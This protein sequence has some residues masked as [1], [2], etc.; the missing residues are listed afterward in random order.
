MIKWIEQK[1]CPLC[2]CEDSKYTRQG[3]YPVIASPEILGGCPLAVLTYRWTCLDCGLEYQSPRMSDESLYEFYAS[4]LYRSYINDKQDA[5]DTYERVRQQRVVEHLQHGSV[6]D[7]GC[8][9]GYLLEMAKKRDPHR[10]VMGVEPYLDYVNPNVPT[11]RRIEDVS[12]RWDNVIC[13]HVI[14]HIGPLVAFCDRLI[15][16]TAPGGQIIIEVPGEDKQIQYSMQHLYQFNP[17]HV[18]RL[19]PLRLAHYEVNPHYMFIFEVAP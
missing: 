6:L 12:G 4:G 7:V 17:G 9:H 13:L 11:V 14:E 10:K 8:S 3:H 1:A 5:Q 16:L 19:F 15:A 2:G 18:K